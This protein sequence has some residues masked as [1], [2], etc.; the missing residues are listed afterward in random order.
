[1]L[2]R[3]EAWLAPE[4]PP[5]PAEEDVLT[6]L[7]VDMIGED[8]GVGEAVGGSGP[9]DQTRKLM[10]MPAALSAALSRLSSQHQ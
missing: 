10:E 7:G 2:F 3:S 5:S 1:M 6:G 8:A 9:D 4:T